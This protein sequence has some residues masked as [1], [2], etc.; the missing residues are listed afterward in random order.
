MIHINDFI[1]KGYGEMLGTY[2]GLVNDLGVHWPDL[3]KLIDSLHEL[4]ECVHDLNKRLE[5]LNKDLIESVKKLAESRR[6]AFS[7]E[8]NI[9]GLQYLLTH[10]LWYILENA[11]E[12]NMRFQDLNRDYIIGYFRHF[13]F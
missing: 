3:G 10:I 5:L 7:G 6:R 11:Y 8:P 1:C 13:R 9:R 2:N 12:K 4:C